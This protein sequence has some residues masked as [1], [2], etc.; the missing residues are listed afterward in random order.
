[1]YQNPDEQYNAPQDAYT[2]QYEEQDS[3]QYYSDEPADPDMT[4]DQFDQPKRRSIFKPR[5]KKPNFAF[6]VLV[7]AVRIFAV[8]IVLCG[9]ALGGAVLGI[10]KGYMETAPTLDLALLDAQD[11][12]SFLYDSSG[13]VITDYKGTENRVMVNISLMPENLRNAFVAVEDMRFYSHNGID[14][15]RIIGSFV[16]NFVSG[17]QQGG[18]TITQQL[19]KNTVLSNELSYKRKIQEAYLAMQLET[20][21]SKLQILEY[22]LNTI[23]MGENYYGV[24]VA[25]EGYFGKELSN[26]TLR[27]CAMLAGLTNNPY[28]YNPRRNFY[29]RTSETTDYEK[30]TNDRTDYV[31]RCMYENQFITQQQYQE[32]LITTSASVLESSTTQ[33]DGMYEYAHYVEYAVRDIVDC[34]LELDGLEDTSENRYKM[35]NKLRTGGYHVTLA[36]DTEIQSIVESTLENASYPSLRDPSDK[37]YR[38]KN[39]DG[40]YD[41]I[42]QP[43]AAAVVLDYR[44]GELKAIV[45]SRSKVTQRKTLNRATDMNMPIGS[46]I[47]PIAVY[48]P[49]LELGYSP[50]SIVYN[51]PVPITGWTGADG[52]DTWPKNYGGGN[53]E[54][55]QTLREAMKKSRNVSAA[56]TLVNLVGVDR[57]VDFLLR[58]G[59]DRDNIDATPFG[60]S[61]GSS[62]ITPLQLTVAYGVLA[63]GGVYQEPISFLGISDSNGN[64]VYDSHAQQDRRQVFRP[65]TSW[66][67]VDMLKHVVS[68]GTGSKAQI[69]GQT[70]GGK[71]GTN[72]DSRGITFSGVTGWY[73]SAIWVGHDNYKP[74]SSNTTGSGGAIPIWVSYMKEIHNTK[75]LSNRDIVEASAEDVGLVK[76]TTCA[77]SGQLATDACRNDTRGYGTVTDY[78][79]EPTVPTVYCQMHQSIEVCSES[80]QLATSFCPSLT[81]AGVVVIPSGHPLSNYANDPD[82]APVIAEYLG[83]AST[84][85]YCFYHQEGYEQSDDNN[86]F[87]DGGSSA[88]SENE[89]MPDARQLLINAYDQTSNMDSTSSAYFD[90]QNAIS[91]LEGVISQSSP[92]TSDI[93]SAM[94]VLT[95]AMAS[96]Y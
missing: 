32:A 86:W 94:A 65:S 90:I 30:L 15:K 47:K 71:T 81:T 64:V 61:L 16:N 42:I 75:N 55:P 1:M 3:E 8:V 68:S 41:E 72:S 6:S 49:A 24:Q 25:A 77:V 29:V 34:F 67:I 10:A 46:T 19:I 4:D 58:M 45:G 60:L 23:Y 51:I 11:R 28:Y 79:Y 59:V 93:A 22:Y 56:Q 52:K 40:T 26:L 89:L 96:G 35:E 31:L 63:N 95:Q 69:S 76:A 33:G 57:S 20:R 85:G 18:S 9:L 44:T 92:S 21:Y 38:G 74:L 27:E 91:N 43:Q 84:L 54:G 73:S 87:D 17:S 14:I 39:N 88:S 78:W 62:G 13:N 70:V 12:T 80:G 2:D 37:I 7:N 50:A 66:M 83:T 48:A 5:L 53:Y 36:I 82:Y